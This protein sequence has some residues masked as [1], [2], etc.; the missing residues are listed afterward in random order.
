M[1]TQKHIGSLRVVFFM[2]L[3]LREGICPESGNSRDLYLDVKSRILTDAK[4]M[5]L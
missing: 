5:C 2:H 3:V 4:G 1:S